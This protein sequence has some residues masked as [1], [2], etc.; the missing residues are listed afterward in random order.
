MTEYEAMIARHSVRQYIDKPLDAET[1]QT[2]QTAVDEA[3]AASGLHIQQVTEE[4]N[5]FDSGLAHYG[6]FRGVRNYFAV[7]GAKGADAQELAGYYGERLVLLAQTLGLNTC[8][9]ALPFSKRKAQFSLD[10]G[11][12][13]IIMISLGYGE[14]Q[15]APHKSK[16]ADKVAQVHGETPQ[17]FAD[18]VAAALTAPT[19]VNQQKFHFELTGDTDSATGKPVVVATALRGNQTRTD[20]GIAKYHFEIGAGEDTFTWAS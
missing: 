18:G 14:N 13:L 7:C 15:G 2:L 10:A 4:P 8:W 17:W 5:A 9:V 1:V 6:R 3:N 20:L 11:E 16:T 19:A 12:K